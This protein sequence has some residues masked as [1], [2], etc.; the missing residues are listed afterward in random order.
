MIPIGIAIDGKSLRMGLTAL[1][2]GI[3]FFTIMTENDPVVYHGKVI[4]Q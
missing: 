3:Y 1:N 2:P 4:R